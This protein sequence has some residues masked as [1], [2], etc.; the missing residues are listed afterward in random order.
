MKVC[1]AWRRWQHHQGNITRELPIIHSHYPIS[2]GYL[3]TPF[4]DICI[5]GHRT[6]I[7]RLPLKHVRRVFICQNQNQNHRSCASAGRLRQSQSDSLTERKKERKKKIHYY[8]LPS[9]SL[10][11]QSILIRWGLLPKRWWNIGGPDLLAVSK[12]Y[13]IPPWHRTHGD[14]IVCCQ[15]RLKHV[16]RSTIHLTY[17]V[18]TLHLLPNCM[19]RE[20][21]CVLAKDAWLPRCSVLQQG[22]L[23]SVL[24]IVRCTMTSGSLK[25][26]EQRLKA[27]RLWL[28]RNCRSCIEG[29]TA[30][31]VGGIDIFN[32]VLRE[33][34]DWGGWRQGR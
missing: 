27:A 19:R 4:C 16:D 21:T 13:K 30:V 34:G 17:R 2:S 22:K 32:V 18:Y 31:T 9:L 28:Y 5:I 33:I 15:I 12:L 23:G 24:S 20:G 7:N 14:I 11:N 26:D 6:S 25:E 3:S 8:W 10:G 29:C 1:P